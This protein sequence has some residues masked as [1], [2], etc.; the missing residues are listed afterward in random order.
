MSVLDGSQLLFTNEF[1]L[2]TID[3]T[4]TWADL[5]TIFQ[6]VQAFSMLN[7]SP[8][9]INVTNFIG[10]ISQFSS[11]LLVFRLND[12]FDGPQTIMNLIVSILNG[13]ISDNNG[14]PCQGTQCTSSIPLVGSLWTNLMRTIQYDG[15]Y[16]APCFDSGSLASFTGGV[17][18]LQVS[19]Q[20][21]RVRNLDKIH[22]VSGSQTGK[23]CTN[24][25]VMTLIGTSCPS[26][27]SWGGIPTQI[28]LDISAQVDILGQPVFN[29]GCTHLPPIEEGIDCPSTLGNCLTVFLPSIKIYMA[30]ELPLTTLLPNDSTCT[31]PAKKY[32]NY[33]FKNAKITLDFALLDV[34]TFDLPV[35][36]FLSPDRIQ[37]LQTAI[38]DISTTSLRKVIVQMVQDKIGPIISE[39]F[40]DIVLDINPCVSFD[41]TPTMDCSI[42][43]TPPIHCNPCDF[44]C[45]CLTGGDCSDKCQNCP[46]VKPYCTTPTQLYSIPIY[47]ILLGLFIVIITICFR[48]FR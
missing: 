18:G 6:T 17:S 26:T 19:A 42:V 12:I 40:Q 16:V 22:F 44:C 45:L 46:C 7:E 23:T 35:G 14:C 3:S 2:T 27:T 36:L 9:F 24:S 47:F 4:S 30:M 43:P 15:S 21:R 34:P 13:G 8:Y 28:S 25:I 33:D 5:Q 31:L 1:L 20:V 29:L 38:L 48:G 37:F 32:T 10:E 11:P 39:L 41:I